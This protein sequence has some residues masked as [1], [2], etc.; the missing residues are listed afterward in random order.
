MNT[1]II[2]QHLQDILFNCLVPAGNGVHTVETAKEKKQNLH[3]LIYKDYN[4]DVVTCWQKNLINKLSNQNPQ[5]TSPMLLGICSDTGG[6]IL[7]GANWGPLFI[8]EQ[9]YKQ[10]DFNQ[11]CDLGDVRVIPHLLDDKYLNTETISHCRQALY[12]NANSE[13]PVS[14]LSIARFVLNNIYSQ[15]NDAKIFTLGGDHSISY[16]TVTEYLHIKNKQNKRTAILHFDAH[17]DLSPQRLGIDINFSTWAYLILS[18]LHSPKDLIQLGIRSTR[19]NKQHWQNELGIQQFWSKEINKNTIQKI[20]DNISSYLSS[21]NISE[22]FISFD[23]DVID[24]QYVSAT[25][26]PEDNGMH[27]D[28]AYALLES[29]STNFNVTGADLS[30][31]APFTNSNINRN[32]NDCTVE[33]AANITAYLCNQM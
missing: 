30:E 33:I 27:P 6:G 28:I 18:E 31:V 21:E 25:G 14:P 2:P 23:I 12:N 15:Y 1:Q 17:T 16:A 4:N 20:I 9:L 22:I 26:T 13:Y 19:H 8:R 7:R 5:K 3:K 29:F 10:V 32:D 11:I 24:S